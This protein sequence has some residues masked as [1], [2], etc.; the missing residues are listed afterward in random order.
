MISFAHCAD[1]AFTQTGVWNWKRAL[2]QFRTHEHSSAHKE[3]TTK[4]SDYTSKTGIDAQLVSSIA[5]DQK[6]NR[7]AL[8]LLFTALRF[9]ARQG[10]AT[11]RHA[12]NRSNY[13]QLLQL[14]ANESEALRTFLGP[15][16]RQKWL[17]HDV[18]IEMLEWLPHTVLRQIAHDIRRYGYYA[19]IVNKTTDVSWSRSVCVFA[20][21]MRSG[22]YMKILL[23]CM[24]MRELMQQHW[25]KLWQIFI[26]I[27]YY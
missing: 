19:I 6:R 8:L 13:H 16:R 20:T 27:N 25:Q 12:D 22:I 4:W 5:K 3:A 11:R 21:L 17:S 15:E 23:E 14:R 9:L 7:E 26:I 1:D 24:Q 2:D 10:L 18:E